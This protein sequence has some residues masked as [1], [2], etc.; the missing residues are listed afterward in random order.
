VCSLPR[1]GTWAP[2]SVTLDGAPL[3]YDAFG[4]PDALGEDEHW[5]SGAN[6]W[7][8]EGSTLSTWVSVA[9]PVATDT[10]STLVRGPSC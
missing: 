4:A 5:P 7:G 1:A 8:Y 9:V 2:A 3:A 6:V 10:A